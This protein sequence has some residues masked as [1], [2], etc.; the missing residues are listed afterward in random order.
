MGVVLT[1][2]DSVVA[3]DFHPDGHVLATASSDERVRLWDVT[4]RQPVGAPLT[5]H[6]GPVLA[7]AFSPAAR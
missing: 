4:T 7:V 5:G 6:T 1:D 2:T 3:V